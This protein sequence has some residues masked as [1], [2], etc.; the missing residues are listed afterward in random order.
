[1]NKLLNFSVR[2]MV[3]LIATICFSQQAN[4]QNTRTQRYLYQPVDVQGKSLRALIDTKTGLI[5]R[6]I[7]A[8]SANLMVGTPIAHY[9]AVD[10]TTVEGIARDFCVSIQTCLAYPRSKLVQPTL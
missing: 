9:R 4:A 10:A 8:K 5:H 2:A 7:N 1:M 6:L 3:L